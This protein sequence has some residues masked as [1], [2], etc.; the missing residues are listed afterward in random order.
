MALQEAFPLAS[1]TFPKFPDMLLYPTDIRRFGMLD[2]L[3]TA[4]RE[5]TNK[6]CAQGCWGVGQAGIAATAD[7]GR[8][9][10]AAPHCLPATSDRVH[11]TGRRTT[12]RSDR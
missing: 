5:T 11:L 9:R 10:C 2:A 1:W 8:Q 7:R 6:W 4:P 3:T 12:R